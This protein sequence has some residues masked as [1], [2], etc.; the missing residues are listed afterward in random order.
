M[1]RSASRDLIYITVFA[2]VVLAMPIW[3][4]PIGADY[5]D[6][7]QK[8][9]IYGIFAIG[10]N[11]LFGMTGYLSFGHA[12]FLGVGS[13]AAVWSFKL[14]TMNVV[15]AVILA[16]LF[17]GVF[18]ALIGYVSLKRSGIYFSILTL[19]FAQM[20]YNLAYSVLTP[21]TN[22]ETGLQPGAATRASSTGRSA[23]QERLRRSSSAPT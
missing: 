13:Y 18:A 10:F 4:D 5:P 3:L 9:V 22:G 20:C 17:G 16:V 14:L 11:I 12:A 15:P 6:L 21:I 19:A 2:A 7:L 1:Q 23:C 8:F